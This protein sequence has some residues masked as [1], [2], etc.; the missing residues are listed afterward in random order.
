P[1]P[2]QAEQRRAALP[3]SWG[4]LALRCVL[5]L[6]PCLLL[7]E[8]VPAYLPVT[9][10]PT[11]SQIPAVYQWLASHGGQQPIAELPIAN[12]NQGFTSKDEAWY[13]YYAIYHPHPIVNGWSGYRPPLTWQIAGL[14][15]TFPSQES[16]H[17]LRSYHIHYVVVHLQ[18]YSPDAASTLRARLEASPDLQR[19]AVFGS[20]SVWQVR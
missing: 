2:A 19:N 15:Q 14:L 16:L 11:G 20:D 6:I 8:A 18:L 1:Q 17:M 4:T 3:L 9:H 5:M 7:L 10:V 12:G 13:D